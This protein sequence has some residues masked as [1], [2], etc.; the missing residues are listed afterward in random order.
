MA[1][2]KTCRSCGAE[3]DFMFDRCLFCKT[4]LEKIEDNLLSDEDLV[5]NAAD[6][7]EKS[8][9]NQ[10]LIP[11]PQS[12]GSWGDVLKGKDSIILSKEEMKGYASKY[13]SLLALRTASKPQLILIYNELLEKSK[14]KHKDHGMLSAIGVGIFVLFL[15]IFVG[16]MTLNESKEEAKETERFNAVTMEINELISTK[17]YEAALIMA[18][19]IVWRFNPSSHRAEVKSA[20][21][22]REATKQTIQELI[23]KQEGDQ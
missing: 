13:L 8:Y 12:K 1:K 7:I 9:K 5:A 2:T 16:I 19:E 6:W 10:L 17:Q 3:N 14:V 15:F 18:E 11:N 20:D 23:N 21:K 4:E 22:Q